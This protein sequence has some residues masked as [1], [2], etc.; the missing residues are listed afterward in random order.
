MFVVPTMQ[1]IEVRTALGQESY[2]FYEKHYH[3][4]TLGATPVV[5][6]KQNAMKIQRSVV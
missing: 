5:Y 3:P 6:G 4:K 2:L 1:Q